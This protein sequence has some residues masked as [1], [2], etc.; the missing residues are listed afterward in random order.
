MR[1]YFEFIVFALGIIALIAL[2]KLLSACRLPEEPKAVQVSTSA[3]KACANLRVIGCPQDEAP[4]A[5]ADSCEVVLTR[6]NDLRAIPLDCWANAANIAAAQI[7]GSP[8][9]RCHP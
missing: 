5:G 9:L 4:D 3:A 2:C 1:R 6:R 7:C 8:V